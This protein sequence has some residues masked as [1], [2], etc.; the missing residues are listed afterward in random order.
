VSI[1]G[2]VGV[3]KTTLAE[4]LAADLAA[5][6]IR[7]DY[8]GN[9]FL[10][11]SYAGS[12]DAQLPA[13]LYFLMS[14]TSQLAA[15]NWPA[16]GVQVADYGF[17]Q[18]RVFARLRLGAAD[19]AIYDRIASE[20]EPLVKAPD[21]LICL[22]ARTSTLLERI[23]GRGRSFERSMAP[24]MLDAMAAAYEE[25]CERAQCPVFRIDCDDSDMRKDDQR[26]PLAA[27]LRAIVSG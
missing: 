20:V 18:D 21:V 4:L 8:A 27:R 2:P 17:C 26:A 14:R 22:H 9:P 15:H 12:D 3:G 11:D 5:G 19:L 1:I 24:A 6:L 23:A 25:I 10:A 13:Q 7:E 16:W